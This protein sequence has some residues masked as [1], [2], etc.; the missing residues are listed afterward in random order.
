[1]HAIPAGE[2]AVRPATIADVDTLARHRADMFRDMGMLSGDL[3]ATMVDTSRPYV[4]RLVAEGAYL[5]WLA[6][7]SG[8]PATIVGG[9]GLQLRSVMPGLRRHDGV[10]EIAPTMQGIVVN[11]YTEAAWRRQGVAALLMRHVLDGARAY[12]VGSL[13]L[14]AAPAGRPLYESMGF[15]PT[16]EM[17]YMLPLADATATRRASLT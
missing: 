7:P 11:V 3:H 16:N 12:G 2:F 9:A 14:H 8:D 5:A 6:T 13:V 10:T 17:R 15:A 4:E 1:M